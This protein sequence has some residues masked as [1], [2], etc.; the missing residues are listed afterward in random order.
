MIAKRLI[1]VF[2]FLSAT[3]FGHGQKTYKFTK[4]PD[5][6]PKEFDEFLSINLD[7]SKKDAHELFMEKV[8]SFWKSDSL[9]I[10]QKNK[11]IDICNTMINRRMRGY[12]HLEQLM[13]SVVAL[14][15]NEVGK[16][17]Y[18]DWI[19]SLDP[20]LANKT[21]NLILGYFER[22]R[23]LILNKE[24]FHSPSVVWAVSELK[25]K[26]VLTEKF[27]KYVFETVD[28]VC[29]TR[30]DSS[31]IYQTRGTLDIQKNIWEG[32]GGNVFWTRAQILTSDVYANLKKYNVKLKMSKFYADSVTYYDKRWF[33]EPLQG[34]VIEKVSGTSSENVSYPQFISYKM[35]LRIV[36]IFPNVDFVGGY[37]LLGSK[38]IG[39]GGTEYV[40][41]SHEYEGID[42]TLSATEY[43]EDETNTSF[44]EYIPEMP[45]M[46]TTVKATFEFKR[47]GKVFVKAM[48]NSFLIV[49]DKIQSDRVSVSILLD[50]DS[51]YHPG[52]SLLYNNKKKELMVYR[53]DKGLSTAP[54]YDSY[55]MLDIYVEAF[56]W[57]MDEDYIDMKMIQQEGSLSEAYFES[58][59]YYSRDRYEKM[60]GIDARNPVKILY[61]Y[62]TRLGYNEF[63]VTDF[64]D[65]LKLGVDAA[66]V[67]LMNLATRGFVIYD[68]NEDYVIAKDKVGSYVNS[69]LGKVDYDVIQL[70]SSVVGIPNA[71]LNLRSLDL[72]L[73]GVPY[74]FLSDSQ[75]VYIF[76][77]KNKI[78]MK[79]NR[80]F[81]FDGKIKAGRFDLYAKGCNFDYDKFMLDLPNIDSLSFKVR[82]FDVNQWGD[83]EQ[84]KV[85][86]VIE[87]LQ[88]NVLVDHPNNKSGVK[89]YPEY[90]IFNSTS[91]SFVYYDKKSIF[92]GVY[93]R[94]KF[95]YKLESFII[96]SLDNFQTE[97]LEF[98]GYLY[99]AGIFPDINQPLKVQR[100]YSLGFKY[101]TGDAGLI[102]Y[103]GKGRQTGEISISNKGLRADGV[104][105]F[106]TSTSVSKDFI[107]FPDSM[108]AELEKYDIA[109]RKTGVEY[110]PVIAQNV[111]CRWYPNKDVMA[112]SEMK[113]EFPIYMYNNEAKMHG[114][115]ALTPKI[116]T[117]SGMIA[118][119]DAEMKADHYRFK[120]LYY[121]TDT[122]DFRLKKFVDDALGMDELSDEGSDAINTSNFKARIDFKLRKGE[123]TANGGQKKVNFPENMYFCYMDQFVW[124]MDKDETE[125]STNT[126]QVAGYDKLS[127]KEKIDL[128][129]QGS[130]FYSTHPDQDSLTFVA[131]RAV[132]KRR[133]SLIEAFGVQQIRTADAAVLPHKGEVKIFRK[134][135][136]EEFNNS[137]IIAN[138]TTKYYELYNA[139][140]KIEGRRK[141]HGRA[142]F[143]YKDETGQVNNI[144]FTKIYVDTSGT[145]IGEGD[146]SESARFALSPAFE[147]KGQAKMV[148]NRQYLNFK[149]GVRIS[150]ECDT[151]R[152]HWIAFNAFINPADVKIPITD[153]IESTLE[154]NLQA[155]ILQSSAGGDVYAIF[156]DDRG[157]K[158]DFTISR[159]TGFLVYDK[160]SQEYR[161]STEDKLKQ[162]NL[163]DNYLSISKRTCDIISEGKMKL[164][165]NPS[166]IKL[167]AYGRSRYFISADSLEMT[168]SMAFD[169][170]FNDKAIE[171]MATDLNNRMS[172]DAVSLDNSVFELA[173]G[174]IF[175]V[176]KS[177]EYKTEIATQGGA[178]KRIP[179]ELQNTF[180]ISDVKMK[181][182]PRTRSFTSTGPIGIASIGKVQINKYF[183]GYIE[184]EN[185]GSDSKVTIAI[186][187]GENDFY[188]FTFRTTTGQMM[189]LSSNNE[190]V[191]VVKETKQ[192]DRKL[193]D[194]E[195]NSKYTY[196]LSS[197]EAQKKFMKEMERNK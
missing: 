153:S 55:H 127:D 140:V 111:Y 51:I 67:M 118:I 7:K 142:L 60:Q 48:A 129:I 13:L 21:I 156:L 44:E 4:N 143:D 184:I 54:F 176:E 165:Q 182:N 33:S 83:Y 98:K 116:L 5:K 178:F 14:N 76:P 154:E 94:D 72:Q 59:N 25:F 131:S 137:K 167:D 93:K 45:K 77:Y 78:V 42:E 164:F 58:V 63:Y 46:K 15:S 117:G 82:S 62:I 161:I 3:I 138:T 146:I 73:N 108:N 28:L 64:A 112:V 24:I 194:K 38:I 17:V 27:P 52:L 16:Q 104:L 97:G 163:P 35:D 193:K 124:Y 147:Y 66:T 81:V 96:D 168:V 79:K 19:T 106:I 36:D 34:R 85:N 69:N 114:T 18:N 1:L 43:I 186:D 40:D 122:C 109:E 65:Y 61:E 177:E 71:S 37:S 49:P 50:Q 119:K 102:A 130:Q 10:D 175:G 160:V 26:I 8:A 57:K 183:D 181:Y 197:A 41:I 84:V 144:Y 92:D 88:G 30:K 110:P 150:H 91:N 188:F 132:F 101:N 174:Q 170:F 121:N 95:F 191:T 171:L 87:N 105:K 120:N 141:Y 100:D 74:V 128:D 123:F 23:Y 190:F 173:L 68:I 47:N 86:T 139:T 32:S 75:Q 158:S 103:N 155:G 80:D 6:F 107:Y 192:E 145:S 187:L 11:I 195:E 20:Y 135:D 166:A 189:A 99:S 149:G 136:I 113:P 148:A 180:L 134:A 9:D 12:P 185:K 169:F 151:L 133:L 196:G 2:V 29:R 31:V 56:Y 162:L 152:R 159:A 179:K 39:F 125:F 53:L 115:I 70:N 22:S 157:V 90:P 89:R 172:N 126:E